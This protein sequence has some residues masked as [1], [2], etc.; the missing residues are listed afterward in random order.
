MINCYRINRKLIKMFQVTSQNIYNKGIYFEI[1][2]FKRNF[3]ILV[4]SCHLL[5]MLPW[6][7]FPLR[8][9][10]SSR[11]GQ[12]GPQEPFCIYIFVWF[13]RRQLSPDLSIAAV[14]P[15][16]CSLEWV[17]LPPRARPLHKVR[18]VP[19]CNP[20]LSSRS[21]RLIFQICVFYCYFSSSVNGK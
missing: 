21:F 13:Y 15:F 5:E 1:S 12:Q 17:T 11:Y 3:E 19:S 8:T 9:K 14:L 20:R 18:D 4:G 7:P 10:N 2:H 6:F 16:C